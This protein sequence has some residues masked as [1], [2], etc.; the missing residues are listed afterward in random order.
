MYSTRSNGNW[1]DGDPLVDN[2]HAE[3][4][5]QLFAR[6]HELLGGT[7][8]F[9]IN[10]LVK[11]AHIGMGAVHQANAHRYGAH[12]QVH[13]GDHLIRFLHFTT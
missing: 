11:Y 6:L 3:L 10:I 4:P 13:F 1:R 9:I 12:I 7:G 8:N 5:F 2:R